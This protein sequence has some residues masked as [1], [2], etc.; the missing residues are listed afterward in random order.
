MVDVAVFEQTP[1]LQASKQEDIVCGGDMAEAA[2]EPVE[3]PQLC[4]MHQYRKL[5]LLQM[6]HSIKVGLGVNMRR[7]RRGK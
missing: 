2:V 7:R 5:H 4:A 3:R 6:S 1:Q